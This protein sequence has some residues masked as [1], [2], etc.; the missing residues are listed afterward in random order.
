MDAFA[1]LFVLLYVGH[2]LGD[3]VV[4][5]DRQATRKVAHAL[6]CTPW[7]S[8]AYNQL[9]VTTYTAAIATTI[10]V[11]AALGGFSERLGGI[12]AW[13]W[14][15]AA[16]LSWVTHSLIDRRWPVERLMVATGSGPFINR[17]GLAY[18]DQAL[19]LAVLLVIAAFLGRWV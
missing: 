13:A 15:T 18:V 3:Y 5:T 2:L 4:Q 1:A 16:A 7:Q 17:G 12:P 10:I 11:S 14:L 8:W 6:H 19:H 9:H